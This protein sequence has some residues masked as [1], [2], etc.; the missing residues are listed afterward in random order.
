[1]IV[2]HKIIDLHFFGFPSC[3]NFLT[4]ALE[5][6]PNIFNLFLKTISVMS[7]GKFPMYISVAMMVFIYY[8]VFVFANYFRIVIIFNLAPF[9]KSLRWYR[10]SICGRVVTLRLRTSLCDFAMFTSSRQ[11]APLITIA[12]A[13]EWRGTWLKM[14]RH[15]IFEA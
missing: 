4:K 14:I 15:I 13:E 5:I 7:S 8:L 9:L 12:L 3:W 11:M 2:L 6:L 1:M 10:I